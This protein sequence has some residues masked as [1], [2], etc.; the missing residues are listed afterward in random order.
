MCLLQPSCLPQWTRIL[1][2]SS[3]QFHSTLARRV[4]SALHQMGI[5]SAGGEF[6][7]KC[8][9]RLGLSRARGL[10]LRCEE[11]IISF[12]SNLD[13][14]SSKKRRTD[15]PLYPGCKKC[16][17]VEDSRSMFE[18]KLFRG[19]KGGAAERSPWWLQPV[20]T[21]NDMCSAGCLLL[22]VRAIIFTLSE[23]SSLLG[24]YVISN[25]IHIELIC[26]IYVCILARRSTGFCG[27]KLHR[28][29]DQQAPP[30]MLPL[31]AIAKGKHGLVALFDG[32]AICESSWLR[33]IRLFAESKAHT[34]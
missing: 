11:S 28:F 31:H 17:Q 34:I 4:L 25:H 33:A 14:W 32:L 7:I 18:V 2:L 10:K 6:G 24:K 23:W 5:L 27:F 3:R 22:V 9:P 8:M 19:K 16:I 30:F 13:V 15:L 21:W 29:V 20:R 26:Y 12:G 1:P